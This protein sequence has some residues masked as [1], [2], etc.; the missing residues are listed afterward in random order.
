MYCGCKERL[1]IIHELE[2]ELSSMEQSGYYGS[3]SDDIQEKISNLWLI[4]E[5]CSYC[6]VKDLR[7]E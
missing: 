5:E 7:Q 3:D 6:D 2:E 1:E 4:I